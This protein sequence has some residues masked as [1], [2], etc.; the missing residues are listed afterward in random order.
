M[1]GYIVYG[2]EFV[3]SAER[4]PLFVCTSDLKVFLLSA[5][6]LVVTMLPCIKKVSCSEGGNNAVYLLAIKLLHA[7]E[8]SRAFLVFA[9]CFY[10]EKFILCV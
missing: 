10:K 4:V 1:D 7:C 2:V 9:A 3:V 5:L 6:P 8:M